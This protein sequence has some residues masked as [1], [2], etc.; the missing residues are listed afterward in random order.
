MR[1]VA[2]P[3][4][5][6]WK[7]EAA[8]TLRLA[9]PLALANMLQMLTYAIDVMFIARLGTDELAASSLSIAIFGLLMWSLQ[10]L[11]G[12][13]AP[14]IAAE[15]GAR[16]PAL[17]PVRRAM[18][19]A[20]WLSVLL[21]AGAMLL[22]ALAEPFMLLTGQEPHIAALAGEYMAVLLF[23]TIPMIAAGVLRNFV[24][25]L[26]R[27]VFA[28]A[29][30]ALGIGVNALGNWMFIFGNWGAPAL[31]LQGAAVAT[32]ITSLAIVAFYVIAIR[33]DPRL[34]RYHIFGFFWRPDWR[35]AKEIMAIGTPIAFTVLA[36]AG[37][38]GAAVFLMG[39]IGALELAAHAIAIQIAALAFQVP[40]GVG[41]AAT[42]RVGY[43]YGA[44]DHE[45]IR[46]AGWTSLAMGTSFM[47]LTA[48]LMLAVPT[49]L[50]G[51]YIETATAQ[52][53]A[54]VVLAT[55]LLVVAAAFQLVD[56]VQ[57]VAAGALRGLKDTRV[58]MWIAI[59]AYWVPGFGTA[60]ALGFFTPLGGVGVWI[61]LATGLA[62][63]ALLL[64]WRWHSRERYGLTL[65]STWH[66]PSA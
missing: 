41:Q 24:S 7:A 65:R 27:P 52:N 42:I 48:A 53:A 9:G 11:T 17:R 26:G 58:P 49:L 22:C 51:I 8:E 59:F 62:F 34:A 36:E 31:G 56:G 33:F 1:P 61:G 45:G 6:G 38:F 15:L 20:L 4:T 63:A 19:M 10:S 16:G 44:A 37:V 28:T 64:L 46:R 13:V 55:K 35:R 32:L 47:L 25:A 40:M 21:G 14:I 57:V 66:A 60:V 39:R 50:L 3:P 2:H 43:F 18:R 12:A 23:A 5:P 54:L 30:T 29:I